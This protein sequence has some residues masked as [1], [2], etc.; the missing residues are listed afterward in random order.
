MTIWKSQATRYNAA[1]LQ[2]YIIAIQI[3]F[4]S[5]I[6]LH[7]EC[8]DKRTETTLYI[9]RR[10]FFKMDTALL[11]TNSFIERLHSLTLEILRIICPPV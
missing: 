4:S 6:H 7:N 2:N 1:E 3:N 11:I 8:K 10:N 5:N 9:S